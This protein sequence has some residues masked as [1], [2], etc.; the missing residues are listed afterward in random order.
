MGISML[1]AQAVL[2]ALFR[3]MYVANDAEL[4]H[5]FIENA[6]VDSW[7]WWLPAVLGLI[8]F[9]PRSSVE[10]AGWSS[11]G[12]VFLLI[13]ALWC[14]VSGAHLA[15]IGYV[16]DV[17]WHWL[18]VLSALWAA[19]WVV[20]V[21]RT[22]FSV[23]AIPYW[24]AVVLPLPLVVSVIQ[25]SCAEA[26][27]TWVPILVNAFGYG[28]LLVTKPSSRMVSELT[29]W[30]WSALIAQGLNAFMEAGWLPS[31]EIPFLQATIA[32]FLLLRSS[33]SNDPRWGLAGM[34]VCIMAS[35]AMVNGPGMNDDLAIQLGCLFFLLHSLRWDDKRHVGASTARW[36]VA[37]VWV[38][39]SECG[40]TANASSTSG[41]VS[42]GVA[43]VLVMITALHWWWYGRRPAAALLV[44]GVI[45]P[46]LAPLNSAWRV[47][48]QA[49]GGILALLGSIGLFA[50]GTAIALARPR[51]GGPSLQ[52]RHQEQSG[53]KESGAPNG[54]GFCD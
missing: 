16:Y 40:F 11:R 28:V 46:L 19:V 21:R 45:V 41:W 30:A 5:F 13:A 25:A 47:I 29:L 15:A 14:G 2:P 53:L 3:G 26:A 18:D 44:A 36:L 35:V 43:I 34:A 42:L 7:R 9:L 22:D 17:P 48:H 10:T 37:I 6:L 23:Q 32:V 31:Q 8:I 20:Y 51:W 38:M 54:R 27:G 52:E 4:R 49:P 1:L 50:L 39:N 33:V 12:W 24:D